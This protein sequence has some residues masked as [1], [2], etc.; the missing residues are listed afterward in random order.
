MYYCQAPPRPAPPPQK[1]TSQSQ[2]ASPAPP[3]QQQRPMP[4]EPK[5]SS[6]FSSLRGGAGSL[7]KNIKDTGSKVIS[8]VQQ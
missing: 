1:A 3:Q 8:S 7:F 4:Q 5:Q 2:R 6:L